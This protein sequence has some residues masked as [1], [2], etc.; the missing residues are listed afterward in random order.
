[1]GSQYSRP[2]TQA[3]SEIKFL[4]FLYSEWGDTEHRLAAIAVGSS[5]QLQ[6]SYDAQ[7]R[8]A[9]VTQAPVQP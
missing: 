6:Y 5:Y 9:R 7:G 8:L 1:M 4:D 3:P 2:K